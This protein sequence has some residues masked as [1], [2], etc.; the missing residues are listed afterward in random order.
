MR[1]ALGGAA[2]ASAFR[3]LPELLGCGVSGPG[4]G[5]ECEAHTRPGS[6]RQPAASSRP[7]LLGVATALPGRGGF[8]VHRLH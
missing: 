8:R 4:W 2:E 3:A 7:Q 5:R 6:P 1:P